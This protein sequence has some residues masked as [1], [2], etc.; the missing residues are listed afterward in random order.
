MST[1]ATP[2]VLAPLLAVGVLLAVFAAF[3]VR[4]L[5]VV[6]SSASLAVISVVLVEVVR[7]ARRALRDVRVVVERR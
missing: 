5:V 1:R 4:P 7:R 3:D 6:L 2:Y